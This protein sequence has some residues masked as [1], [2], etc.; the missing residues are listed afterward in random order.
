MHF[1][2]GLLQGRPNVVVTKRSGTFLTDSAHVQRFL[3][4]YCQSIRRRG[5]N[6]TQNSICSPALILS[7]EYEFTPDGTSRSKALT[8]SEPKI[9]VKS[10]QRAR[11]NHK[12]ALIQAAVQHAQK[13]LKP[14]RCYLLDGMSLI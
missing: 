1:Y 13:A 8:K 2:G 10:G 7:L 9:R 4:C 5:L 3:R 14:P 12:H 6:R 11:L